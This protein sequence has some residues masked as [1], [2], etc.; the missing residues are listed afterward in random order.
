[1]NSPMWK[2]GVAIFIT[3]DE[4]GG[5]YDHVVPPKVDDLGLGIRVPLLVISP[6]AQ[7][8]L[9]DHEQGEFSSV[10]RFIADNWGLAHLTDRVA[11]TTNY[12]HV[13]DFRKPSRDPD[14]QP[15]KL[16][17]VGARWKTFHD[18]KEWPPPFGTASS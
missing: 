8:G 3:W 13:F 1:M 5:F 12:S 2:R 16:D 9:V 6:Y 10:N 11:R 17:C 18:T 7:R 15:P 4:W 14:P